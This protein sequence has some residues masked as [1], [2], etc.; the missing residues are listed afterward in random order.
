MCWSTSSRRDRRRRP[1]LRRRKSEVRGRKLKSRGQRSEERNSG[2]WPEYFTAVGWHGQLARGAGLPAR[3]ESE[4]KLTSSAPSSFPNRVSFPIW[5]ASCRPGQ[6]GSLFHPSGGNR[7]EI[8]AARFFF[9]I[10]CTSRLFA[11]VVSLK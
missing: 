1:E 11:S 4:V 7:Y 6:A 5:S 8:I 10:R 3:R 2:R 9:A